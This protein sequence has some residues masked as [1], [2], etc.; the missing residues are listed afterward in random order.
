MECKHRGSK[1]AS[2]G[3]SGLYGGR[4]RQGRP[5][6]TRD[7]GKYFMT[8]SEKGSLSGKVASCLENRYAAYV[9]LGTSSQDALS[10]G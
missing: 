6:D 2:I 4:P 7:V 9:L 8:L 10:L 1:H 3:S 5:I